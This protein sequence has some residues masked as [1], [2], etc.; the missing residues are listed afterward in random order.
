MSLLLWPM[1]VPPCLLP[2]PP[3]PAAALLEELVSEFGLAA[4]KGISQAVQRRLADSLG[5]H[6]AGVTHW[7]KVGGGCG[8]YGLCGVCC[9]YSRV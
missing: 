4:A 8:L 7:W 2:L 9:S 3:P 1:T 5:Q 6:A